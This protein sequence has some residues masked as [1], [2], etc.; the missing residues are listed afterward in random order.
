MKQSHTSS[1]A[2]QRAS[3]LTVRDQLLDILLGMEF[4]AYEQLIREVLARS[5]YSNVK[6]MGRRHKRGRTPTGGHDIKAFAAT[7]LAVSV[8]LT[9]VKQYR[10]VVPRRFVDELRGNILR[11]G[12]EQGLLITTS[13]FSSVARQAALAGGVAPITLLD[14][15]QVLDLLILHRIGVHVLDNGEPVID[16]T[17]FDKWQKK[18]RSTYGQPTSPPLTSSNNAVSAQPVA[19]LSEASCINLNSK[20]NPT[21]CNCNFQSANRAED[22]GVSGGDMQW[23]THLVVGLNSLWLVELL[24]PGIST[25][26]Y[27]PMIAAAA[28]GSLLPDLD[29]AESKI[30]HLSFGGIKPFFLPA[31][32]IYRDLGHRGLLHSGS[33]LVLVG[34]A[35]IPLTHW[36]SWQTA[37]ALFLGYGS[38]LAADACTRSGIPWRYVPL[39][40]PSKK[41]SHLLPPRFRFVTGS[42]AEGVLVPLLT[43]MLL[44]LLLRNLPGYNGG[45][46]FNTDPE[47]RFTHVEDGL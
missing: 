42:E 1:L 2:G 10:G 23:R 25:D 8:T 29:A 35:A 4:L 11:I 22:F 36:V 14:G 12:A 43:V 31:Q 18:Y 37:L 13:T 33:A 30:K 47:S 20:D 15:E 6:M 32:I 40:N 17:F 38:H 41:R 34:I 5:G 28:L 24:P 7:D 46:S 27:A 19:R 3:S 39:L 21:Q 16:R 45:Q 26:H 9:Q 44:I